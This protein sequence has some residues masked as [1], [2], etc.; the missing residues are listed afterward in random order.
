MKSGY[1]QV[2]VE[3]SHICQT[4]FIVG[5]LGFY[6]YNKMPFGLSNSP[7]TYQRLVEECLRNLNVKICVIYLDNLIIFS[8]SLD[9]FRKVGHSSYQITAV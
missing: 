2:S 5:H 6:E 9:R 8:N 7:A 4:A 1:H 3:E